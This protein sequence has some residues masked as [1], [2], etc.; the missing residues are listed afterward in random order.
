MFYCWFYGQLGIESKKH[1]NFFSVLILKNHCVLYGAILYNC[2]ICITWINDKK[3]KQNILS[4]L[5]ASKLCWHWSG[6]KSTILFVDN[7]RRWSG[8]IQIMSS[9]TLDLTGMCSIKCWFCICIKIINV[10]RF[11]FLLF[12]NFFSILILRMLNGVYQLIVNNFRF[13]YL[14]FGETN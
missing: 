10:Y 13:T 2:W 11:F 8:C 5:R 9:Y 7:C 12:A 3:K 6:Y 4:S 1:I 14:L